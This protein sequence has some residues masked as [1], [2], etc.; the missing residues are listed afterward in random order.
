M[1]QN[2]S[3]CIKQTISVTASSTTSELFEYRGFNHGMVYTPAG[4]ALTLLT[5]WAAED[6]DGTFYA[7]EDG[8]GNAIT[9]TVAASSAV[10]IPT[11]LRGAGALL[12]VGD[13]AGDVI[14]SL[15]G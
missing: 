10:P 11:E 1:A 3:F 6:P 15:K 5:W 12:A 14:V 2:T 13:D 4:S 9:S 7:A 8:S